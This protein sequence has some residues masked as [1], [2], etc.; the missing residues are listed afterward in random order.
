MSEF[1]NITN[2]TILS[3]SEYI[4]WVEQLVIEGKTSGH[5]QTEALAG[6]TALNLKRMQ[7][8]ASFRSDYFN[9]KR[10]GAATR[11]VGDYGSMVWG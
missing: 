10:V 5:N 1:K 11:L 6:F 7:H 8:P 2:G 3:Y 9:I 4:Q